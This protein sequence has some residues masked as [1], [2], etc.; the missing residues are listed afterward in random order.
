MMKHDRYQWTLGENDSEE[1]E[2]GEVENI[3][4]QI[5]EVNDELPIWKDAW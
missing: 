2:S 4:A 3:E 5:P 1:D